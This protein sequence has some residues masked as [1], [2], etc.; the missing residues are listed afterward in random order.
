MA[1]TPDAD[2]LRAWEQAL[3][4]CQAARAA[5]RTYNDTTWLPAHR[6]AEAG[7]PWIPRE[8]NA[9]IERLVALWLDAQDTLALTPSPTLA[10]VIA[11]IEI[12]RERWEGFEWP[13]DWVDAILADLRRIDG[14]G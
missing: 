8:I 1:R 10:G 13:D 4:D 14:E 9:E 3:R 11:K 5:E 7:G 12:A 6:E 2:A